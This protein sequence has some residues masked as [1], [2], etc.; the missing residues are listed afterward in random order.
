VKLE[1]HWTSEY[2]NVTTLHPLGL[3][4]I[5][6]L[7]LAILIVRRKYVLIPI[8]IIACFISTA[9]RIV[10]FRLDFTSLRILVFVGWL[11]VILKKEFTAFSWNPLDKII[12]IWAITRTLTY[13]LLWKTVPSFV[14]KLGQAVDMV[15]MYFLFRMV[16]RDI[17]DTVFITKSFIIISIPVFLA[18]LIE[19]STARNIFSIL[20]G[21]PEYTPI[22]HGRLR[23]QGAYPH[24]IIAGGF[25]ASMIP[26]FLAMIWQQKNRLFGFLGV[27]TSSTIVITTMSSTPLLGLV[28]GL[29]GFCFFGLRYKIKLLFLSLIVALFGL[30]LYMKA[31]VWALIYRV[32]VIGG[33]T[34]YHRFRLIDST[35]RNFKEWWLIGIKDTA[36]WGFLMYDI[37][38][39]YVAQAVRGGLI[40]LILYIF[41]IRAVFRNL[42]GK[43]REPSLTKSNMVYIWSIMA[44]LFVHL[45]QFLAV[46][47]F[48]QIIICWNLVLAFS[49][50]NLPHDS[51]SNNT[52]V[53]L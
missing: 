4:A 47:Y 49:T 40:T 51:L 44:A 52:S 34:G 31:P 27:I 50:I 28:A 11:R 26:L 41:L 13:V 43:L 33:S 45:V 7:S 36:H 30:H 37:T 12:I 32:G 35:I 6:V 19:K 24:P 25:W 8:I 2:D 38:N 17:D 20:G 42:D 48:G 3:A 16:I 18:F 23:C 10:V 46:S 21:V 39:Q 1:L 29:I 22:R 14:A 15:G 5:L 9:Q 53:Q